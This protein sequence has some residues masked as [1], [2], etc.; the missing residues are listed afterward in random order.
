LARAAFKAV[1]PWTQHRSGASTITMQVVRLLNKERAHGI[2]G[3]LY[4]IALARR[5]ELSLNKDQILSLYLT[6]A[7]F[8]GNIEGLRL[9]ALAYYQ[10]EPKALTVGEAALLVGL[11]QSPEG[12][13]P[14]LS[15]SQAKR[16]RDRVLER[17][18]AAEA[19]DAEMAA[20]AKRDVIPQ[21][22][23]FR[24]AAMHF[25]ESARQERSS[26]NVIETTLNARLQHNLERLAAATVAPMGERVN[27]AI[28]VLRNSDL[29]V[30]AYVGSADYFS[31]ER[32]GQ[33]DFVKAPRSPGSTL[34]P[35]IYGMAF[36][37]RW[38]HPLTIVTD[39]AVQFSGYEPRNFSGEFS[40]DMSVREALVRSINTA[41][42]LV[43]ARL[44][45]QRFMTRLREAGA[46][47]DYYQADESPGLAV[48]L[49]G[50]SLSLF[51]L[52][53]LFAAIANG[54]S[55]RVPWALMANTNTYPPRHLLARD[56]AW[57][58]ADI[59][60]DMPPPEGFAMRKAN[61]GRRL[62][63]KTGTSYGFRDAW[64]VG[65]DQFHTIGVWIGRPDGSPNVG[66][67]GV[68]AAAPVLFH[69][70]D[71]LPVPAGDVA[72]PPP[73]PTILAEVEHLPDHLSRFG[74]QSTTNDAR[75]LELLFPVSGANVV[76]RGSSGESLPITLSVKGGTPPYHWFAD[77][78]PISEP[79]FNQS[80]GWTPTG[81]GAARISVF[82]SK[83][84]KRSAEVW[85]E[86]VG[87]RAPAS[88]SGHSLP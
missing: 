19:I 49:G 32:A 5:L 57:A 63:Y 16:A 50:V 22:R 12:R 70:F 34:K 38:L 2:V 48:G 21:R 86:E 30:R 41:A 17:A 82:D 77:Q 75:P 81:R 20:R 42:V 54:G 64:A 69:A 1:L 3:K 71:L 23:H 4:Q 6:L 46:S 73:F 8:G 55:V 62:A 33:V 53:K 36:E 72:G 78:Q 87:R 80:I 25:A 44:E 60:A 15:P 37:Q 65:F 18:A 31:V 56:A 11:P 39:A 26:E 7:P 58:L 74:R 40:G 83:G 27:A 61:E 45:P 43:L 67:Y 68:T 66:A 51:D 76:A 59:L 85:V 79:V 10:K 84:R 14:D 13:R 35:F 47:I 29:A 9:A 52:T 28:L 88:V 24:F